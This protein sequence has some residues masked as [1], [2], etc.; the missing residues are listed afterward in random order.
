MPTAFAAENGATTARSVPRRRRLRATSP[1]TRR[2]RFVSTFLYELP[3]GRDRRSRSDIGRG[4]DALVGGWDVTG[5][6]AAAVGP[7]PDAV[8]QQRRSVGHGTTVRGF[9]AT[10]RPDAVG[11]G[12]ARRSDGRRLLRSQRAFVRP[13]E[14]HRPLRQR[15]GR[16]RSSAPARRRFSMTLGKAVRG[17]TARRGCASRWRSRTCST[18]RT[19]T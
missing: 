5:V 2:H 17:R 10:Q 14:Q 18:S 15:R 9:T 8:L 11:D 16:H 13:A 7:V 6:T 12:N 1:F 4:L 3:F 19:S